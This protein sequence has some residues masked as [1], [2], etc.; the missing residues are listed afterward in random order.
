MSER[1]PFFRLSVVNMARRLRYFEPGS[2]VE[3]T[4]RTLHGLLLLRPSPQLREITLGVLG[5]AQRLYAVRLHLFVF[6]SNHF[7]LLCSPT[8][9]EQLAQFMCFLNS[10]LAREVGRLC[11]WRERFWGRRYQAIPVT[12][13]DAAQVER[14]RY[15]LAHGVKEGLVL[16]PA[17]WPGAHCVNTLLHGAPLEGYWFDRTRESAARRAGL[18]CEERSFAT[19]ETVHLEPLPCWRDLPAEMYRGRIVDLICA[20][21]E[22]ARREQARTGYDP[23]GARA[24]CR[25]DPMSRPRRSKRGPAPAIHASTRAA[26]RDF[27]DA[28]RMFV[29]AYRRAAE[30]LRAEPSP[31]VEFP[32]LSI[33]PALPFSRSI[34]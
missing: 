10:N 17:D 29:D 12:G 33:P 28:Y 6:L 11:G 21:E 18:A 32:L 30:A 9:P 22:E 25:Q 19:V 14:L 3:V 13:E 34:G 15:V 26:R 16:T 20:I 1:D 5:R 24:V 4:T 23:L 7:H 2:L 8:D 31:P 27:R